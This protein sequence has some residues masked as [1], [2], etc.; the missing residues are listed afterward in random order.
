MLNPSCIGIVEKNRYFRMRGGED[1][2]LRWEIGIQKSNEMTRRG[3]VRGG[4]VECRRKM[5]WI[6]YL[7]V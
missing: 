1:E 7:Y 6:S 4:H 5:H 2:L 3:G